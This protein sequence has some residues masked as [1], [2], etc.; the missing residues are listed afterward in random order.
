MNLAL[1]AAA[2]VC[3]HLSEEAPAAPASIKP[4]F[5]EESSQLLPGQPP[6]GQGQ[7]ALA[8]SAQQVCLLRFCMQRR[9]NV[10]AYT[11][12]IDQTFSAVHI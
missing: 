6:S 5:D 7:T 12:I 8:I 3:H 4:A 2:G 11:D 1:T 10:R 9:H